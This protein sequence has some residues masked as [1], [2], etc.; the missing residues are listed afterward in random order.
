MMY[1]W[2]V[3]KEGCSEEREE[4]GTIEEL[5][6]IGDELVYSDV[7]GNVIRTGKTVKDLDSWEI[8]PAD[9]VVEIFTTDDIHYRALSENC[10]IARGMDKL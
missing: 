5:P 6:Q 8:D 9:G 7:S 3:T 4:L 1:L 2:K 10:R